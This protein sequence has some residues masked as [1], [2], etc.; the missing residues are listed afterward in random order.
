[1]TAVT[2]LHA[3]DDT[4]REN[5]L[6]TE[7]VGRI[8][9]AVGTVNAVPIATAER[10]AITDG[11]KSTGQATVRTAGQLAIR[12]ATSDYIVH[13][14]EADPTALMLRAPASVT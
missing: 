7:D 13:C 5:A 1:M 10:I 14:H 6:A 3:V 9:N 8:V 11:T 12:F 2:V 4:P